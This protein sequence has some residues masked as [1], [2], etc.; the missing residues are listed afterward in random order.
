M[1][2]CC[3]AGRPTR[4][5]SNDGWRGLV[6]GVREFAPGFGAEFLTW[7]RAEDIRRIAG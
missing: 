2:G 6:G 4:N 5:G 1:T 7:V 3:T